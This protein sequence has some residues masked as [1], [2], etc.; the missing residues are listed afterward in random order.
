MRDE[1]A[2][3]FA[4]GTTARKVTLRSGVVLDGT[5]SRTDHG[6]YNVIQL[7]DVSGQV[8]RG[9]VEGIR[10]EDIANIA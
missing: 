4:D 3:G 6:I 1:D 5:L 7:P 9:P 8:T 2:R 10:V